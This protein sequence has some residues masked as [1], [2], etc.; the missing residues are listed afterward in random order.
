MLAL[1]AATRLYLCKINYQSSEYLTQLIELFMLFISF[2]S[3]C[4]DVL[5]AYSRQ[6]QVFEIF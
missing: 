2:F 4:T 5:F 3:L 1:Q 6:M